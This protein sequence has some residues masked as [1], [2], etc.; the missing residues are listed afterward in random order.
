[1]VE[2]YSRFPHL[3]EKPPTVFD[4]VNIVKNLVI[5]G[6]G[7]GGTVLASLMTRKLDMKQWCVTVID[8]GFIHCYQPGL[9]F[10]PFN[11]YGYNDK[12]DVA[13][14]INHSI[15]SEAQFVSAE[16]KLIDHEN[17]RV[18]TSEGNF[19]YDFLVLALGCTVDPSE[20]EGM[21][22]GMGRNIFTFY[23]LEGALS[24]QE[25]LEMFEGGRI[26]LNIAE[27][28]IKCPVAPIEFVFLADYFFQNKNIRDKVTID[29]VTPLTGAFTK[30]V[31]TSVL[32]EIAEQKN[33]GIIPNFQISEVDHEK[34]V[35]KS[36]GGESVE[37]D[38]LVAI[39]PNTGPDVIEESG[40]GN[41]LGYAVTDDHTLKVKK[42][43]R[44][45]AVGDNTN[46]PTSKAGSVAHFE[47][48]VIAENIMREMEGKEPL[49]EFD[50]H[51]NC[52][53]ESGFHKALLFDFNYE[54]EPLKGSYP[55]GGIGPFSLLKESYIN[56]LG[57]LAFKHI[58]WN[59]L[60]PALLPGDPLL[61]GKMSMAGKELEKIVENLH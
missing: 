20:V 19:D 42:A 57:K 44:I 1:M 28:P 54:V 41:G 49:P 17:K 38:L 8:K 23:T 14:P 52:F 61:P 60:L 21:A 43:E 39:P 3:I 25:P 45:Y 55:L 22:E 27:M 11:L 16:I 29:F 37:Y 33:I 47:A 4:G 46:V 31:A 59:L 51:S 15:P 40:L 32:S 53:I 30:P 5:L 48:E 2:A 36:Y 50:G 34:K 24:M 7:T 18:E 26:V 12:R 9:L 56:H 58:Y 10:L 35:I 13:K 6:A